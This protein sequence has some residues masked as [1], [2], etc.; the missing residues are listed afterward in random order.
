M[1]NNGLFKMFW[2]RTKRW[3]LDT[4]RKD[5]LCRVPLEQ[6]ETISKS[7]VVIL[8]SKIFPRS[9]GQQ[10]KTTHAIAKAGVFLFTRKLL[11]HPSVICNSNKATT[12]VR[13]VT[14]A[15]V[16]APPSTPTT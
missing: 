7:D 1:Y 2:V 9:F 10:A 4:K 15:A 11:D 13:A 8:F 6:K 3:W 16:S 14:D 12:D 5:I